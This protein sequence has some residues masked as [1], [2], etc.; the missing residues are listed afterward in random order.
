MRRINFV[1]LA[2]VLIFTFNSCE[3]T[4]SGKPEFNRVVV[5]YMAANNNLNSFAQQNLD[6]LKDGFIPEENSKDI[7]IVYK[8]LE[9]KDPRLVRLFKGRAGDIKED[10]VSA[11]EDQNSANGDVLKAV[12]NRVYKIFPASEYGLIL[13][14]HATG[15][16]PEGYYDSSYNQAF[17]EDPYAHLVKSFGEDRGVE[18]EVK[19]LKASIP[20]K[21]SFIL[22]DCCLMGGVETIYELKDLTDYI[23]ASPTEILAY[24]FPY[25]KIMR[26]LF[27]PKANLEEVCKLFYDYYN[28]ESGINRSATIA[29]YKTDELSEL[30]K[31]SNTIFNNNREKIQLLNMSK[32]QPYFRMNKHW[33]WDIDNLMREI[34]S[35]SEYDQFNLALKKVVKA[36]WST[37][38]FLD[39][40]INSFSGLSTYI[41]NPENNFLDSFYR[42]FDWNSAS[43]MIK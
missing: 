39:I 5:L 4:P 35:P 30:A 11:Y 33:F 23:I 2:L 31:A 20:Y 22:F 41:Q 42:D 1:L 13:W 3:K 9:G 15:W 18:M 10:V 32:I 37:S 38:Y 25:S 8:H 17:M 7:L 40:D 29:L 34:A 6:L 12:L 24:G 21:F 43:E 27:K 26:P 16:L 28:N 19:E 14:S 36:K